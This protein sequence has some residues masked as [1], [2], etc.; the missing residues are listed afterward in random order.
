MDATSPLLLGIDI[1]TTNVK[2]VIATPAGEVVAQAQQS[3]PVNYVKPGWVEQN[4]ADWWNATVQVVRDACAT[5]TPERIAGIG[6]SGQG[7]AVTLIDE[8]GE[9]IRPAIIWMDAR[10]EPQSERLRQ[11]CADDILRLNGKQPAPYNADPALMWVQEHEPENFARAHKSLTATGYITFRLSGKPIMN[12]SDASILFAFDLTQDDFSPDLI[13]AFGLPVSLYPR[14]VACAD[15]ISTLSAEAAQLL[16]LSP[17]VPVIAGGEDTS[18][19]GLA[20]GAVEPGQ[21]FLSLGTAGTVYAAQEKPVMDARLL[22]FAHVLP[23]QSLLGGSMIAAGAALQ[24]CRDSFGAPLSY[25][26][27]TDLAATTEPGADNL[28]FLPYL[29]GELQPINDGYARGAFVGLSLKTT[30]AH[31]VRAVLEGTAYAIAHN[32]HLS[33]E[34]GTPIHEVRAVGAPTQSAVW[35]QIIADVMGYPLTVVPENAGAPLGN[36]LLA[37]QGV[38]LIA[39]AGEVARNLP[40]ERTTYEPRDAYRARYDA[41]LALYRDLYPALKPHYAALQTID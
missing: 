1:G 23:G 34:L 6:V 39:D 21:A 5:I 38:G 29:N 27:L 36:A 2:A 13:K 12:V 40:G 20:L 26:E 4:P 41:L 16:G 24:W 7:C 10:S 18:S 15:V 30:K 37:A 25:D 22:T 9:V 3:Y 28:I 31:M 17:D 32:L 8:A 11:C 14:V 33:A 35:C 19:A